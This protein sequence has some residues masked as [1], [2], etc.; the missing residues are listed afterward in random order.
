MRHWI[1]LTPN[2][3]STAAIGGFFPHVV[4]GTGTITQDV[5]EDIVPFYRIPQNEMVVFGDVHEQRRRALV[6]HLP[7]QS[8]LSVHKQTL[9]S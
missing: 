8:Q 4:H 2:S 9:S 3:L 5:E 7:G 6:R 1:K